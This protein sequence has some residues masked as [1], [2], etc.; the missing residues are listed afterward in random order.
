M[1]RGLSN[2]ISKPIYELS[3]AEYRHVLWKI[4]DQSIIQRMQKQ[5]RGIFGQYLQS[6]IPAAALFITHIAPA[7]TILQ[8]SDKSD[9]TGGFGSHLLED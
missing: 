3:V 6:V 5:P 4:T 1:R 8:Y 7:H 2:F 9:N